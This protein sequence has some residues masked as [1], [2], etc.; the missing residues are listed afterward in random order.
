MHLIFQNA[1]KLSNRLMVR[2]QMLPELLRLA[3][4][5]P[6]RANVRGVRLGQFLRP[7]LLLYFLQELLEGQ[8]ISFPKFVVVPDLADQHGLK[9]NLLK[10]LRDAVSN[11]MAS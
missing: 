6:T 10:L 9:G 1:H 5:Q 2:L 7:G 8:P 4:A 3:E 11:S